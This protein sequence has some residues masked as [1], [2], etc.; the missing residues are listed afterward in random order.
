MDV[1]TRPSHSRM[2][3]SKTGGVTK[4]SQ[5]L[6]G[7]KQRQPQNTTTSIAEIY[8]DVFAKVFGGGFIFGPLIYYNVFP[9]KTAEKVNIDDPEHPR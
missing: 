6:H 4:E 3:D 7:A 8:S 5:R 2:F 1:R 9:N